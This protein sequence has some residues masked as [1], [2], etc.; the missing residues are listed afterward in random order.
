MRL[1]SLYAE[2]VSTGA[3]AGWSRTPF[4]GREKIRPKKHR[5]LTQTPQQYQSGGPLPPYEVKPRP[6]TFLMRR[7]KVNPVQ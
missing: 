2:S 4:F 7:A 1:S 3:I 5:H 6:K